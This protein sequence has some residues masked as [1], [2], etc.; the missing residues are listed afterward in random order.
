M[1]G[2]YSVNRHFFVKLGMMGT[3][4]FHSSGDNGVAGNGGVCLNSARMCLSPH[5]LIL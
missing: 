3:T 5:G 1:Q 2:E 4:V